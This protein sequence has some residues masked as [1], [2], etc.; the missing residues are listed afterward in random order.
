MWWCYVGMTERTGSHPG[1]PPVRVIHMWVW[2]GGMWVCGGVMG[3]VTGW[4][5]GGYRV[6]GVMGGYRVRGVMGVT[7]Y[8]VLWGLQGGVMG[9]CGYDRENI[10]PRFSSCAIHMWLWGG[11]GMWVWGGGG[12]WLW[13]VGMWV[14]GGGMW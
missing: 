10:G 14:W 9:L 1:S 8:V 13:G 11:G 3:G 12:M 6:R 5:Y 4:C 7:G 2:G